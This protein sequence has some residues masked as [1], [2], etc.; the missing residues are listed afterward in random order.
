MKTR[1]L[2]TL[3]LV[4]IFALPLAWVVA[5]LESM[6]GEPGTR[7]PE[8]IDGPVGSYQEAMLTGTLMLTP[9]AYLPVLV[10][11]PIPLPS[12]PYNDTQPVFSPDGKWIVFLSERAGHPDIFRVAT[13]GGPL[14]NLSQTLARDED[15]PIF[16]PDGTQIAYASNATDSGDWD[17]FLMSVDGSDRHAAIA[18]VGTD[19]LHPHFTPDGQRLLF[20]SDLGGNWDIYSAP[21]GSP[22]YAWSR[23]TYDPAADRYP[24]MSPDGTTIVFRSERSGYSQIYLMNA[25]GSDQRPFTS[26]PAFHL[27][28]YYVPD[29]SGLVYD[30]SRSGNINSYLVNPAGTGL[31]TV[32]QRSG[33][34]MKDLYVSND[35]QK[36]VNSSGPIT[37]YFNLHTDVFTTP[38]MAIAQQGASHIGNN[39]DWEGGVL[40]YGWGQAW[41]MTGQLRYLQWTQN[42]VDRCTPGK[43]MTHV[44]DSLLG[45]AAL[46]AYEG[47]HQQKYLTFAQQVA[48]WLMTAA[49]RTSDGTLVHAEA[50]KSVWCDTIVS[51]VPFLVEMTQV[52]SNT[53][54]FDEAISQTLKHANRLQDKTTGLYHHSWS[55]SQGNYD[56]PSYW[57]RGNGW[58]LLGDVAVLSV[59]TPTHPMRATVLN[60][61]RKQVDGLKPLQDVGG[62]WHT[63]V[64]RPD[65]YLETSGSALMSY[66]LKRGVNEG[67][68]DNVQ[69]TSTAQSAF[70]G[71]WRQVM[72]DGTVANVSGPTGPMLADSDYNAISHSDLQLYGQG[73]GLLFAGAH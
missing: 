58:A 16:S 18:N 10:A 25:D 63:V 24:V 71:V 49:P 66:A 23:L 22:S 34:Q 21:L 27:H 41:Q 48:D 30:S 69:Y 9:T 20:S 6:P 3:V 47:Y 39:C 73:L 60:V 37:G 29:M 17:I 36:Q 26:D 67:W 64:T 68:L 28:G 57:G 59:M 65:F 54:Y 45:Y 1:L 44:N 38:L 19:E 13:S 12:G 53:L 15:A 32:E 31:I 55:E 62:L 4:V 56:G 42:Y 52:T 61:M 11:P 40:A 2:I 14:V 50:T 5:A 8:A 43:T 33:W 7:M 51:T 35:G 46:I 70:L 72:A